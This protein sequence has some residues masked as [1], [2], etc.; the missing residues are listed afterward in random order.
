[1]KKRQTFWKDEALSVE[2]INEVES[3]VRKIKCL[4]KVIKMQ[5]SQYHVHVMF[6]T[7]SDK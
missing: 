3:L 1:M 5:F 7:D 6:Q 2:L 4:K